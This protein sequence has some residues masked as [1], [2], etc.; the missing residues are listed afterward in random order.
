MYNSLFACAKEI[1][2]NGVYVND[3]YAVCDD[4]RLENGAINYRDL[5]VFASNVSIAGRIGRNAY[6]TA[7]TLSF[8]EDVEANIYGDLHYSTPNEV[9]IRDGAVSGEIQ[10]SKSAVKENASVSDIIL[11]YAIDLLQTL[12]ITFIIA[13]LLVWLTPKFADRVA[14]ISVSR[15]FISLGVGVLAPIVFIFATILLA[16][17]SIGSSVA[18]LGIFVA[19]VL[20]YIS[21][22]VASIYFGKLFAKL[23]KVEGM[24]KFVLL[25]LASSLVLWAICQIPVIGGF[26]SII[27]SLFGVGTTLVNIFAKKEKKDVVVEE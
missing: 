5:R 8:A 27:I 2:I 20:F 1:I 15:S 7:K 16:L 17:S 14:N 6:I 3:I 9:S 24:F 23:F 13:I 22:S 12:F 10:Y 19:I 18:I 4:F 26:C 11:H 25:T 21:F